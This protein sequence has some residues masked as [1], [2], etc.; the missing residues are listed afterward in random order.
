[1]IISGK[2]M[3][4]TLKCNPEALPDRGL[5]TK[6][7]NVKHDLPDLPIT[8]I[9]RVKPSKPKKPKTHKK[10]FFPE[11]KDLWTPENDKELMRRYWDGES[12]EDIGKAIGR[13]ARAVKIRANAIRSEQGKRPR[14]V[15]K[16][17]FWQE[18][19]DKI[20]IEMF[21]AGN[22]YKDIA[23]KLGRTYMA[24]ATRIKVLR[25]IGIRIEKK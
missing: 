3:K 4:A 6:D 11:R 19:E 23:E 5:P 22:S 2:N 16:S 21:E 18:S 20:L 12:Y 9:P 13:S 25:D 8:V 24:I 14:R 7:I 10:I 17:M 15:G 1:M